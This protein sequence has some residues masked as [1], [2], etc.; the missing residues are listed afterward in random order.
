MGE[1]NGSPSYQVRSANGLET[2]VHTAFSGMPTPEQA[3]EAVFDG[4][5]LARIN[6]PLG[7]ENISVELGAPSSETDRQ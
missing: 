5:V 2:T 1:T 4:P 3:M 6:R 7:D